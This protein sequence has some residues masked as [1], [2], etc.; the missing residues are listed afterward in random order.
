VVDGR[1]IDA[2]DGV[3]FEVEDK[4][5]VALVGPSGCGKSTVLNMIAGLASL[6][7][8]V[9][10]ALIGVVIGEFIGGESGGGIGYLIIASLG[11]LNAADMMVALFVLGLT[12]IVLALGIHQVEARL[13]RWRPEYQ[14]RG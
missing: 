11:T 9:S 14:A 5:F 6:T 2:V 4:E 7:P 1:T 8:S 10:F 3:S 13:L 12:G